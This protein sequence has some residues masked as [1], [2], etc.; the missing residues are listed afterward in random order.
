MPFATAILTDPSIPAPARQKALDRIFSD[1][2]VPSSST[3]SSFWLQAPRAFEQ[4]SLPLPNEVDVVIIGSGITGTSIA[5][6]L[7]EDGASP[8]ILMLEARSICSGATGRNGGH[9]LETADEY[10][11]FADMFGVE[12][13]KK[14]MRFRLGHLG[15]MLAVAKELGIAEESQAR[16]VQFLSVY[17][18]EEPW[19]SA[20]ERL[21]RFKTDMPEEAAEWT[22]FEGEE[23]P[24]VSQCFF[25]SDKQYSSVLS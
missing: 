19:N 9:I 4:S 13:A 21:R 1:P 5:R 15:E 6:S 20:V 14:L 8:S 18:G 7:L 24:K 22:S 11:E 16:K 10:A 2:G 17:F 25:P 3:T 12:D 23:I